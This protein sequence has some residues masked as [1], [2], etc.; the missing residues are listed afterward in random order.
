LVIHAPAKPNGVDA[1]IYME[2]VF[3]AGSIGE[4]DERLAKA[5]PERSEFL[6]QNASSSGG[7]A[8]DL[9]SVSGM[10]TVDEVREAPEEWE[11]AKVVVT[12]KH[13]KPLR[14]VLQITMGGFVVG[15]EL[16][17]D[18]SEIKSIVRV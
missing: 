9:G 5:P 10:A 7:V 13:Q 12:M 1:E 11:W 4:E 6:P 17:N 8:P 3:F 16:V 2:R 15:D 18:D 14:G